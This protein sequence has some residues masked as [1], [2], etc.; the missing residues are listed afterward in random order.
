MAR[1]DRIWLEQIKSGSAPRKQENFAGRPVRIWSDERGA[2]WRAHARGYTSDPDQAGVYDFE[3]AYQS[4][5]HCGP[6]K[7][8]AFVLAA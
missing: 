8:I 4:I 3:Q 5:S 2:W 1:S 7:R 6:E